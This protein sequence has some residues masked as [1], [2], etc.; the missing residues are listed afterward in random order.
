MIA[1]KSPVSIP[2][3][4]KPR[5]KFSASSSALDQVQVCQIPNSFSLK[6]A[7]FPKLFAFLRNKAGIDT[8]VLVLESG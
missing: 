2:S 5:P 3:S 4:T 6:A 1:T 8:I 7:E